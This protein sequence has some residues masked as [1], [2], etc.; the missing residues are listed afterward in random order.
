M[1]TT[2]I[3]DHRLVQCEV[4][5]LTLEERDGVRFSRHLNAKAAK[6]LAGTKA[7][8]LRF[9]KKSDGTYTSSA[10]ETLELSMEKNFPNIK[11]GNSTE[12]E[13]RNES[14]RKTG[15]WH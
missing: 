14:K 4:Q 13:L 1:D 8:G 12:A 2:D 5:F 15:R 7:E 9:P 10:E 6:V 3:T 11:F